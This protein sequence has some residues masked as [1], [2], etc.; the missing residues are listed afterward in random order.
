M[1]LCTYVCLSVCPST[2]PSIHL[3]THLLMSRSSGCVWWGDGHPIM[4]GWMFLGRSFCQGTAPHPEVVTFSSPEHAAFLQRT[5]WWSA[6]GCVGEV[7][8]PS[9]SGYRLPSLQRQ[10]C[11]LHPC[12]VHPRPTFCHAFPFQGCRKWEPGLL[13]NGQYPTAALGPGGGSGSH[14][15]LVLAVLWE[16]RASP[17]PCR[18][19]WALASVLCRCFVVWLCPPPRAGPLLTLPACQMSAEIA[20][21]LSHLPLRSYT[22]WFL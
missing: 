9:S 20:C 17:S 11:T 10:P 13:A 3:F 16:S 19:S 5:V 8:M 18:R 14:L 15:G 6:R 1:Y 2:H 7:R 22:S 12:P 21:P 4:E